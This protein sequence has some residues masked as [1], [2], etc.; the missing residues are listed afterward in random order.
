MQHVYLPLLKNKNFVLIWLSQLLSQLTINIVNFTLISKIFEITGSTIAVSFLWISYALPSILLLPLSGPVVDRANRKAI[1]FF[2]NLLQGATILL[3]LGLGDKLFAIYPIVFIYSMMNQFYLPAEAASI[4]NLVSK[5]S[6]P[7]ANSLFLITSQAMFILG[8]GAVGPSLSLLGRD[9]TYV[10]ASLMLL[11]AAAA[12][13]F[14]PESKSPHEKLA[15]TFSDFWKEFITGFKY[16]KGEPGVL[17]PLAVLVG[18]NTVLAIMGAIFPLLGKEILGSSVEGSGPAIFIPVGVGA[19]LGTLI[20]PRLVKKYRKRRLIETGLL[21][22]MTSTL[23]LAILVPVVA[24]ALGAFGI[25]RVLLGVPLIFLLGFSAMMVFV[26]SQTVVQE[27]TPNILLGRIVSMLGFFMSI[28][29][30]IPLIFGA[31]IAELLGV[32][33]I[34][35]LIAGAA[36]VTLYYSQKMGDKYIIKSK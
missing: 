6:L 24:A 4:P 9:L 16:I 35:I 23:L 31:A 30:I 1:L 27:R 28:A 21:A 12:V 29:S 18:G 13:T 32:R 34:L 36:A 3:F 8:F 14:L 26:P 22:L 17:F 2:T 5:D 11:V 7:A 25:V 10:I 15:S 33:I 20:V 19:I